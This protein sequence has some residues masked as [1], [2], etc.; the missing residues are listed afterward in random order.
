[1]V[2]AAVE[3]LVER[4]AEVAAKVQDVPPP[5]GNMRRFHLPDLDKHGAWLVQ[6]L[7]RAYPHRT[8][9]DLV[10]WLKG[11][12]YSNEF[13]FLY[14]DHAV[15]LAVLTRQHPLEERPVIQ[16]MFVFAME[17]H[18][19]EAAAFYGEF[20]RWAKNMGVETVVVETMS[21]VPHELIKEK[22]GRL[23]TRQVVFAKL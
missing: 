4:Q 22:L 8:D 21:D 17:G 12:L 6:R 5:A 11:L 13:M 19:R 1:M 15:A 18:D 7:R 2:M 10:G 23:F 16:E 14:Q 3:K 9:R 20:A